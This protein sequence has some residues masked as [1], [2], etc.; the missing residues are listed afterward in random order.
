MVLGLRVP[1]GHLVL[2]PDVPLRTSCPLLAILPFVAVLLH[3]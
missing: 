1:L 2:G 3:L